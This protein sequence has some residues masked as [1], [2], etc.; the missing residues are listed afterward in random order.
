MENG[1]DNRRVHVDARRRRQ[2]AEYA[3]PRLVEIR[4]AERAIP[5]TGLFK[6]IRIARR[7]TERDRIG[8]RD[9]ENM[10]AEAASARRRQA[11]NRPRPD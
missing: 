9:V 5:P 8:V 3:G 1:S 11:V 4:D 6:S 10:H 2:F 7:L